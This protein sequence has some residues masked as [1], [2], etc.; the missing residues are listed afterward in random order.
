MRDFITL[1]SF[2]K[3]VNTKFTMRYGDSQT[4]ELRL[5]E[6]TDVGSSERQIQY[7]LLFVAPAE[8][9][10]AQGIYR[11]EHDQMGELDLFLVPVGKDEGG[12]RYEAIFNRVFR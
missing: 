2:S 7:S 9:P 10:D 1:D 4:A 12:L 11:V 5:V 6:A 3:H 8:A